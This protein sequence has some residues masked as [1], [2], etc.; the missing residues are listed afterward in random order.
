MSNPSRSTQFSRLEKVLKRHYTPV[1]PATDRPVLEQ[2]LYASCL[3]DAQYEKADEAMA[4][5]QESF[6]DW[7]EVRVS[8][9]AELSEEL[10]MLPAPSV[11]ATRLKQILQGVFEG[12]YSFDL[13]HLRKLNLGVAV[14]S[15]GKIPGTTPFVV[16]FV[17]Q[18]ALGGHSIPLD[19][20]TLSVLVLLD[21]VGQADADKNHVPG[22][23]RAVSKNKGAL[24]GSLLH[25]LGADFAAA[26]YSRRVRD[27]LVEIDPACRSRLPKR[28]AGKK[29]ES[30]SDDAKTDE[31]PSPTPKASAAK[32][33]AGPRKRATAARSS[34][35]SR[36]PRTKSSTRRLAR[37]KPR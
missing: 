37:K 4:R 23:E 19:R 29:S 28:R 8:T 11:A 1:Q 36:P 16:A 24:F 10:N 6:F 25:R 15:L 32:S 31:T 2:L 14:K 5:L 20:S 9:I 7:N 22:L 34:P 27:I 18:T 3:E 33:P 35:S 26:P 30:A 21:L 17:T 13:E 12:Q